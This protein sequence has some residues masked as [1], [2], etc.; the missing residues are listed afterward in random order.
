V[1]PETTRTIVN[2]T[3]VSNQANA[4]NGLGGGVYIRGNESTFP[5]EYV[6]VLA[7]NTFSGNGAFSGGALYSEGGASINNNIFANST[8]GRDWLTSLG[9]Y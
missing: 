8:G 9:G 2:N 5:G 1:N 6:P 4:S 3:F 7:N